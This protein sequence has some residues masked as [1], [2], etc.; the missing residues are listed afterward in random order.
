MKLVKVKKSFFDLC[1]DKELMQTKNGRPCVL[2][3]SLK[4]K[5]KRRDFVV[6]LRSNIS[7]NVP[8]GTYKNLPPN[9]NTKKNHH[10]GVHYTKL[11]P[12]SKKYI[13]TYL[14]SQDAYMLMIQGILDKSTKEIVTACQNYLIEYEKGNKDPYTPD[15]DKI[16]EILD[17]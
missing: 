16:I 3:V 11:F 7:P 12:V 13:D 17:S 5:D 15:I 9:K 4:Y 8:K 1:N 2:L 14:I 10:H 6:P